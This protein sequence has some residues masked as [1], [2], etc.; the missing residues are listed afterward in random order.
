MAAPPYTSMPF[1]GTSCNIRGTSYCVSTYWRLTI[2]ASA[3]LRCTGN[4]RRR[5]DIQAVQHLCQ[6][7]HS[8][9][10]VEGHIR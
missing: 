8:M 2:V 1:K 4:P 3:A 7:Q 10:L 9:T 5:A 6:H